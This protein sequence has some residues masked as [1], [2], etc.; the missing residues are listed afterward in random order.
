MSCRN[1]HCISN[2]LIILFGFILGA[3]S[4]L[5]WYFGYVQHARDMIPYALAFAI[6]LF[7][8][9]AIFRAVCGNSTRECHQDFRI[10]PT[11]CS[12]NKYSPLV[13]LT[14]AIFIVFSMVFLATY[15]PYIARVIM[16]FIGS[17][18]FW[19][20]LFAFIG[21]IFCISYRHQ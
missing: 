4:S 8:T 12:V 2:G 18:S 7:I 14:A 11:C 1:R 10:S 19:T 3:L 20:M 21:M 6:I 15:L 17:I 9:T 13:L 16:S 5:A